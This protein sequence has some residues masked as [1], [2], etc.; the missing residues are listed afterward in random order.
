[1]V[2]KEEEATKYFPNIQGCFLLYN[3][4]SKKF[5]K[6]IGDDVCQKR[7]PACST[8]KVP[9]AVMA[10]DSG[11]VKD[12][13]Q[14]FKW[15]GKRSSY[16]NW[17][18]DQTAFSWMHDSVV[19][20]SQRLTPMLGEKEIQKYL[21]AFNYGNQDMS[22][23]LTQ[24][25]LNSPSGEK[26]SLKISAYEQVDFMKNLWQ[27]TFSVSKTAMEIARKMT[28][29][30]T[31]SKGFSLSGKTGSNFYD[32]EHKLQLG[33]FVARIASGSSEYLVVTNISDLAP[34]S[35]HSMGGPRAKEITKQ[36]L[37]DLNLW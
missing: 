3:L 36:I 29:L 2:T 37:T 16:E 24:A 13:K 18:H 9:L 35:G 20:V 34:Y 1:M 25:W 22:G 10:F 31:S 4:K 14:V 19:W 6:V 30:E 21:K 23:G 12:E 26:P 8:F 11:I 7:F 33:W 27:G 17:N 32:K 15:D 28:Y 5:E